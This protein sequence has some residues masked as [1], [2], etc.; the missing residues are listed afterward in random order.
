YVQSAATELSNL[1]AAVA[2]TRLNLSG[3]SKSDDDIYAAMVRRL[4][5]A[6]ADRADGSD[7]EGDLDPAGAGLLKPRGNDGIVN[8]EICFNA[9]L[10]WATSTSARNA[11]RHGRLTILPWHTIGRCA[12]ILR[13]ATMTTSSCRLAPRSSQSRSSGA[14]ETCPSPAPNA[15]PPQ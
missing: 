7:D 14:S 6:S 2:K 12:G 5:S 15:F 4:D 13:P 10:L 3:L 9:L 1:R 11:W 8:A